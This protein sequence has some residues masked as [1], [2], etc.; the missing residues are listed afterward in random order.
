MKGDGDGDIERGNEIG[1]RLRALPTSHLPVF[2]FLTLPVTVTVER[3][4]LPETASRFV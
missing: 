4:L 2:L 1:E 3:F